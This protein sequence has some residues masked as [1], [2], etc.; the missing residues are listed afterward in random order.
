M[1]AQQPDDLAG[2][3]KSALLFLRKEQAAV[4][5]DLKNAAGAGNQRNVYAAEFPSQL[6]LQTGGP[7]LVV[8]RRAIGDGDLHGVSPPWFNHGPS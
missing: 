7:G 8:S 2:L 1:S 5:D 6:L 3:G 4:G